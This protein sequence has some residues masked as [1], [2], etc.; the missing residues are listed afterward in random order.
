MKKEFRIAILLIMLLLI[1]VPT[2]KTYAVIKPVKINYT[3]KILY[4]GEQFQL[5]LKGAKNKIKWTSQDP[6]V[7]TVSSKGRLIAKDCGKTIISAKLGFRT[8]KCLVTVISKNFETLILDKSIINLK[9]GDCYYTKYAIFPK[10]K[11]YKKEISYSSKD[12]EIAFVTQDGCIVAKNIGETIVEGKSNGLSSSCKVIV[13][14]TPYSYR[15]KARSIVKEVTSS[16]MDD[17]SKVKNLYQWMISNLDKYESDADAKKHIDL[18]FSNWLEY[19]S[20]G[21]AESYKN[22]LNFA[23]IESRIVEFWTPQNIEMYLNAVKIEGEWY[24]VDCY[25]S[26]FLVPD[27]VLPAEW[28][29]NNNQDIK[30]VSDKY[31]DVDREAYRILHDKNPYD[32]GVSII[33]DWLIYNKI[34]KRGT[35]KIESFDEFLAYYE[36]AVQGQCIY[37]YVEDKNFDGLDEFVEHMNSM[38]LE[39]ETDYIIGAAIPMIAEDQIEGDYGEYD[40]DYFMWIVAIKK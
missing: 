37:Y 33:A 14:D 13:R 32:V 9:M 16:D 39:Y 22:L 28:K 15:Y 6:R 2:E 8:Y 29:R 31:L 20:R 35:K 26:W 7:V 38:G 24:W 27:D 3:K 30:C 10:N 19:D 17:A 12:P 18:L 34:H 1:F 5:K 36:K 11:T 40:G 4:T 25:D 21:I 23:G